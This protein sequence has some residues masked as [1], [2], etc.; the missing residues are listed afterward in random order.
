MVSFLPAPTDRSIVTRLF[1]M[2]GLPGAG[3]TTRARALAEQLPALRLS[4]DEWLADLGLD[5][6]DEPAR[7]RLESV[8]WTHTVDLLRLG[9][10]VILEFGFWSSAERAEKR[11]A[12]RETGAKVHLDYTD[13][14]LNELVRR[15]TARGAP[16]ITEAQLRDYAMQF[17][18]PDAAELS[19]FDP[20]P[21]P[22]P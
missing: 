9:Q 16:T 2:C 6:F 1:L 19:R 7:T 10:T 20:W 8:L 12:A 4:P 15:V 21:D 13:T 22:G 14:P 5:I 18:T 11:A 3:K 17:E